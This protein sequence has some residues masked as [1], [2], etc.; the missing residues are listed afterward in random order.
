MQKKF[1]DL[2][3]VLIVAYLFCRCP[4]R[5]DAIENLGLNQGHPDI[6]WKN[7]E[8]LKLKIA[9]GN[10]SEGKNQCSNCQ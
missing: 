2:C 4:V 8:E 5:E 9:H 7:G 10:Q 1:L 6:D 3:R